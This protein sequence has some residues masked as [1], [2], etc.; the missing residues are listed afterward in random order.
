MPTHSWKIKA[1]RFLYVRNPYN[2]SVASRGELFLRLLLGESNSVKWF[3]FRELYVLLYIHV[4]A[5]TKMLR[6]S[7]ISR[8]NWLSHRFNCDIHLNLEVSANGEPF[9]L[10]EI[11]KSLCFLNLVKIQ[12][13][14]INEEPIHINKTYN[15]THRLRINQTFQIHWD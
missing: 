8:L 6:I 12:T 2:I 3:R 5:M 11:L 13:A 4:V 10:A 15:S 14:Y 7:Q 1:Y 9:H